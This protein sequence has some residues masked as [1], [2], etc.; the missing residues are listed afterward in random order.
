M[1]NYVEIPLWYPERKLNALSNVLEQTGS[2]VEQELMT[3]LETL[4]E[5]VVPLKQRTDIAETLAQ[6]EQLDAEER[7]R[8]AA[9]AYR[10]SAVWLLCE[11]VYDYWKLTQAWDILDM[12]AFVRETI[13]Q[14]KQSPRAFFEA[15]LEEKENLSEYD[16]EKLVASK[17]QNDFHV[18]GVF[19]MDFNAMKFAF[20][21]PGMGW[22]I[23]HAK[24]IST[25]SFKANQKDCISQ[26]AKLRRFFAALEGKPYTTRPLNTEKEG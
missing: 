18:N 23:Y 4:Y 13:R 26:P 22:K 2:G 9:E 17:V 25:A 8:R 14:S 15:K 20:V 12:A 24:D 16:F 3:A 11:G 1:T 7:A 5:K 21:E 19:V 6:E 10:V